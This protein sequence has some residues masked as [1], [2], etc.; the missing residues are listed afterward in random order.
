MTT[1]TQ[2]APFRRLVLGLGVSGASRD[3]L[4]ATARLAAALEL[5]VDA[6]FIEEEALLESDVLPF[7]RELHLGRPGLAALDHT[8]LERELRERAAWLRRILAEAAIRAHTPWRF[9]RLRGDPAG[10]IGQHLRAGDLF[11]LL[12]DAA[13]GL[14]SHGVR[15][16]VQGP[17]LPAQTSV[18]YVPRQ[19][20][21][22]RGPIAVALA[23]DAGDTAALALA[24]QLAGGGTGEQ[25]LIVESLLHGM[26]GYG[27]QR[28]PPR[29]LVLA[30]G[31]EPL[32]DAGVLRALALRLRVPVLRLQRELRA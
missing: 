18:L 2:A 30:P 14:A 27:A 32:G 25:L 8:R 1:A 7:V 31:V 15:A 29:L 24:T 13:P 10:L 11:A 6:L 26:P 3:A 12:E 20:R 22:H 28:Q 19:I 17:A 4:H 21:H 16:L 9:S 5:E 23:G